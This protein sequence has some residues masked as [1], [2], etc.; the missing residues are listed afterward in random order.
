M[1]EFAAALA[2]ATLQRSPEISVI[3][4]T[5]NEQ[6]N[7]ALL[8]EKIDAVLKDVAWEVIFVDDDSTDRT[9]E[10]LQ[11]LA[12]NDVRV[13]YIHRVKRRGLASAVV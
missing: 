2:P 7:V 11:D 3:V 12:R 13:R 9:L 10:V 5:F 1:P 6:D 8:V 4:P